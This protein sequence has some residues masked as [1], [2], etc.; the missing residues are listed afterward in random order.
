[1]PEKRTWP[2]A[3]ALLG[4]AALCF[5]M[6]SLVLNRGD[7]KR[8]LTPAPDAPMTAA[9]GAGPSTGPATA[10]STNAAAPVAGAGGAAPKVS[11]TVNGS[12][13]AQ[14]T[15]GWPVIVR[16]TLLHPADFSRSAAVDP[17][18]VTGRGGSAWTSS[19]RLSVRNERGGGGGAVEW[20]LQPPGPAPTSVTVA[21]RSPA[22][23]DWYLTPEQ[24]A[25]LPEGDFALVAVLETPGGAASSPSVPVELEV[26]AAP[27]APQPHEQAEMHLLVANYHFLRGDAAS[28][29]AELDRLLAAQPSHVTALALKA[30]LLASQNRFD[31]ALAAC[32]KAIDAHLE[33]S[34]GNGDEPPHDLL[35]LQRDLMR[36]GFK[37]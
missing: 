7:R 20:P 37:E 12:R 2:K 18:T 13:R 9:S 24:T 10:P 19:I 33:Q 8:P 25:L 11:L 17:I 23:A 1:M 32:A 15:R 14:V 28:A 35:Q 22:S 26:R 21:R 30:E 3:L 16:A 34:P 27:A 36:A 4:A 29:L 6:I 31:D 5:A